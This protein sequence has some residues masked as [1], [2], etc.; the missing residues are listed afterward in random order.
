MCSIVSKSNMN[1]HLFHVGKVATGEMG[2]RIPLPTFETTTAH[3]HAAALRYPAR[4]AARPPRAHRS[5][6]TVV[7]CQFFQ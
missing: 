6:R 7:V 5:H 4:P 1:C 2:A 3:G